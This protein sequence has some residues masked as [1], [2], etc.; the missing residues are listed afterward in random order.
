MHKNGNYLKRIS[1]NGEQAARKCLM[2][3]PHF[4]ETESAIGRV[5]ITA[6]PGKVEDWIWSWWAL[7]DCDGR[8]QPPATDRWDSDRCSEFF[9]ADSRDGWHA[10]SMATAIKFVDDWHIGRKCR[11]IITG[12]R[13]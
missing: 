7:D 6:L 5:K 11:H 2:I 8:V 1:R 12:I 10:S 4:L 13:R 9:R 3:F